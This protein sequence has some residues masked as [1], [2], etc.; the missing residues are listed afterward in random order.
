MLCT[1]VAMGTTIT[2]IWKLFCY[3]VN[4]YHYEKFI[5]IRELSE[6]TAVD[7]FNN[8]FTIDTG[9]TEKNI[10]SIDGIDNEGTVYKC[11]RIRYSSSSPQ[12]SY[13]SM[14]SDITIS[15]APTTAIGHTP[16]K[17]VE[18][19]RER[20]NRADRGHCYMRLR[21]ENIF[22]KRIIWY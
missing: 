17:G 19:E 4:R 13:I 6:R 7:C 16:S 22:M 10:P 20:Y 8:I 15:N 3:G 1:N 5:G 18:L 14:L 9:T 11:Q 2:N 12:N 21:H